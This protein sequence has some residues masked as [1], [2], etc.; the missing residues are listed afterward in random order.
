V[1]GFGAT[2]RAAFSQVDLSAEN[3]KRVSGKTPFFYWGNYRAHVW[4]GHRP[5]VRCGAGGAPYDS[6]MT[7]TSRFEVRL[8]ADRR[9]ELA[10]LAAESGLSS[11]DLVRLSI[12]WLIENPGVLLR[13]ADGDRA[14]RAGMEG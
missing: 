11:A 2:R 14:A 12:G 8:S 5:Q 10:E 3:A 7:D 1:T 6:R 13:P 4:A 9:R